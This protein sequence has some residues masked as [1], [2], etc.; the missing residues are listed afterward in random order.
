MTRRFSLAT[1]PLTPEEEKSLKEKLKGLAWW[2]W[3]PNYWLIID[4]KDENTVNSI[5]DILFN[6]NKTKRCIVLKID[7]S[8]WS[9]LSKKDAK[10]TDMCDWIKNDWDTS[11]PTE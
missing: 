4:T 5:R 8:T 3:L 9:A 10:G 11:A 1:D 6:I 2:H 7:K